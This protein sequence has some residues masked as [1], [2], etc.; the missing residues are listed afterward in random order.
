[1][2]E[3]N[4]NKGQM[5]SKELLALV[6]DRAINVDYLDDF[7]EIIL[8]EYKKFTLDPAID[9]KGYKIRLCSNIG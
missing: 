5:S 8:A 1:M 4:V 2:V 3:S 7:N 6:A 9:L